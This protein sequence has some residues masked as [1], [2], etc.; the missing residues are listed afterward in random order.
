MV[1]GEE[2]ELGVVWLGTRE[3]PMHH[4]SREQWM[5]PGVFLITQATLVA[6]SE[7]KMK[8]KGRIILISS[9]VLCLLILLSPLINYHSKCYLMHQEPARSPLLESVTL[10]ALHLV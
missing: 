5:L 8:E 3:D 4:R 1:W 2:V 10:G 9:D 7:G 6:Y